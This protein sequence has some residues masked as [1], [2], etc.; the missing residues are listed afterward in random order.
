VGQAL[1]LLCIISSGNIFEKSPTKVDEGK[2]WK[3]R[4]NEGIIELRFMRTKRERE[5]CLERETRF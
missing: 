4:E 2:L 1:Q 5:L 3:K